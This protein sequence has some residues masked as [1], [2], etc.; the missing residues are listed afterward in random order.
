MSGLGRFKLSLIVLMLLLLL[1][2]AFSCVGRTNRS[3]PI[4]HDYSG[5]MEFAGLVRSYVVH[6]PDSYDDIKPFPLLLAFHG[7]YGTGRGMNVARF[8]A[9]CARLFTIYL[10]VVTVSAVASSGASSTSISC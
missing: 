8:P 7:G 6:I 1:T 5:S 10:T 4:R 2:T 3:T 9:L